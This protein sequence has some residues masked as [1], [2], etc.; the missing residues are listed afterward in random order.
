[1]AATTVSPELVLVDPELRQAAVARLPHVEPFDFLRFT[2]VPR[3]HSDLDRFNF[4][5]EWDEVDPPGRVVPIWVAAP[6]YTLAA[7]AKVVVVNS[8]FVFGIAAVV[9]LMQLAG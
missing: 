7:L 3:R 2:T 6:V 5:A 4:L 1:M 8:V 9:A